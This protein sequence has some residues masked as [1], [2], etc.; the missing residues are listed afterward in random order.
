MKHLTNKQTSTLK[1]L[2]HYIQDFFKEDKTGHDFGHIK[3]VVDL[4]AR[5]L[6][7]KANPFVCLVAAYCHDLFDDKLEMPFKSIEELEEISGL[8]F[9]GQNMRIQKVIDELG[10]KG[11]FDDVSRSLNAQIVYE[12]DLLD[13][14]GAIGIG[15]AFYYAGSKGHIFHDPSLEGVQASNYDEYRSLSRNVI[16]HFDE[17][18]L[19]LKDEMKTDK[20]KKIANQRHE[21]LVMFVKAFKEE[22]EGRDYEK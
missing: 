1:N 20:A 15:R 22:V 10:Y 17:K 5:L 14:S 8:D 21:L 4:T 18:L 3:R 12:A 13:A 9:E 16:A 7:D 11:G 6:V 2:E 19:K